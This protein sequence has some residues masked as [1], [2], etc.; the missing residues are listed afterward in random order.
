M[1]SFELIGAAFTRGAAL[2]GHDGGPAAL[3]AHH[4]ETRLRQ[5]G[6]SVASGI[7]VVDR[8]GDTPAGAERINNYP[9]ALGFLTEMYSHC[10]AVYERGCAPII[11][12]GDHS[13]SIAS[14]AA[15]SDW[16]RTQGG[17]LGVLWVDAHGD[18]NTPEISPSG[19]LHGMSLATLLGF[20]HQPLVE[21]CGRRGP[22]L[23]GGHVFHVGARDIDPLERE[24]FRR[25]GVRAFTMSEVDRRGLGAVLEDALAAL[26]Q[27]TTHLLVSFD[28][29][30]CDP[31]IA[32][33]VGTSVRGGL[34]FRES[35][36]LMEMVAEERNL[37]SVEMMELNPKLDSGFVTAELAVSLLESSL[38]KRIL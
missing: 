35:H 32:P 17:T 31:E 34:T 16:V 37:L 24:M 4:V 30:V 1:K 15:A 27:R 13:V 26:R 23:E 9:A 14:V 20:G 38:G 2:D 6:L 36:L 7:D 5:L 25:V 3:R 22:A 10:R 8:G 18:L 21:L 12:G 33:A 29:D 11:L 19:R 28:L